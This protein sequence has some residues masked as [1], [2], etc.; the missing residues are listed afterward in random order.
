M[1][2]NSCGN[3]VPNGSTICPFCNAKLESEPVVEVT[4]TEL[5]N[6]VNNEQEK[7]ADLLENTAMYVMDAT[8]E[9]PTVTPTFE[10][11]PKKKKTGLIIGIIVGVIVLLI[12]ILG[13]IGYFFEFRS[14]D[15]RITSVVN[16][17]FKKIN[18]STE[19]VEK[20]SGKFSIDG[21]ISFDNQTYD[22][23]LSANY[24]IDLTDKLIN[25]D[26]SLDNLNIGMELLDEPLKINSY[27]T[28]SKVYLLFSNFYDKFIYTNVDGVEKIFDAVEQNDISYQIMLDGIRDAIK[29]SLVAANKKQSIK[30][31]KNVVRIDLTKENQ[32]LVADAARKS[33]LNNDSLLTEISKLTGKDIK[34]LKASLEETETDEIEESDGYF[35]LITNIMG[36]EF[37]EFSIHDENVVLTVTEKDVVLKAYDEGKL[38]G[39]FKITFDSKKASKV[40]EI[41]VK[42]DATIYV[43]EKAYTVNLGVKVENDVNPKVEK[44]DFKN[45]VSVENMSQEDLLSIYDKVSKFGKLGVFITQ[46]MRIDT[47]PTIEQNI[48]SNSTFE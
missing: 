31:G 1:K 18:V 11:A 43:E 40:E 34:E 32:K 10:S 4:Q 28:D 44:A 9:Q 41:N 22:A 19:K 15:K 39:D 47:T 26:M 6:Q 17:I 36:T 30:D 3:E 42:V 38:V 29:E 24:G 13:V 7:S 33:L 20:S 45:S 46:Y 14:A 25:L 21:K 35:E 8:G 27:V 37:V 2:C 48:N 5:T 12:A 23:K 16:N